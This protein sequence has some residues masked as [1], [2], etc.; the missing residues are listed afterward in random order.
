VHA[1]ASALAKIKATSRNDPALAA[2][3]YT[4]L[5]P[6][7]VRTKQRATC[8]NLL[9]SRS[10]G[11]VVIG[12][13]DP[14]KDI[15]GQG[16]WQLE[17][18]RIKIGKFDPDLVQVIR[19][20]NKDFIDYETGLGISISYPKANEAVTK[21]PLEFR[22]TF[23]MHPR[24]GDRIVALVRFNT[25][26]APQQAISFDRNS[27]TWKCNVWCNAAEEKDMHEYELIVARINDDIQIL[28]SYY[29]R[30]NQITNK[31][32]AIEMPT[33]PSGLEILAGVTVRRTLS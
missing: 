3:V 24:P 22:G 27:S 20:L 15:R 21:G 5:E 4:T 23:R 32:I 17:D 29:S 10:V 1:E 18:A 11:R 30:V 33:V 12:I 26:Y 25:F 9:V 19:Q 7:T 16:E 8:S 2:T 31:W 28:Q 14:N 13:L 6:C